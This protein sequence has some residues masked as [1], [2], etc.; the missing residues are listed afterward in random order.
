[1]TGILLQDFP[2]IVIK[3]AKLCM[4]ECP[5]IKVIEAENR[6]DFKLRSWEKGN[7]IRVIIGEWKRVNLTLPKATWFR[8]KVALLTTFLTVGAGSR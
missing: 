3:Y 1:M 8:R 4:A 7:I 6:E 5:S 2:R